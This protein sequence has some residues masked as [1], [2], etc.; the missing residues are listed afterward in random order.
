M[1]ELLKKDAVI[2]RQFFK[3]TAKLLGVKVLY[4]YPIDMDYT[5]HG[6]ADPLGY[7]EPIE[8]DIILQE[9]PKLTT[10]RKL[11]WVSEDP[12][13]KPYLCQVPYDAP[14]LQRYCRIELPA[15]SP[16]SPSRL[17]R[18]TEIQVDQL[19]PDSW[20]CK[21]AP[22]FEKPDTIKEK[23]YKDK[24]YTYLKVDQDAV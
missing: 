22:V 19:M 14:N 23:D 6:N 15:P 7:S 12:N 10:L 9:S 13:D 17:F 18:I 21:L 16:L 1:G 24:S 5:L 11:G 3:E 8:M 4:S 20:Y 2:Y